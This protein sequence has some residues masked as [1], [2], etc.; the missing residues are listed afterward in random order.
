MTDAPR[1]EGVQ[2]TR[3]DAQ[4]VAEQEEHALAHGLRFRT[5][6]ARHDATGELAALTQLCTEDG[7]PG[8]AFQQITAVAKEHRGHRLGLLVKAANLQQLTGD[9]PGA[10]RILTGNAGANKYMIAINE[11]LGF[12]VSDQYREWSL[13]ITPDI[14]TAGERS[15]D[16]RLARHR[17]WT[18]TACGGGPELRRRGASDRDAQR[19]RWQPVIIRGPAADSPAT[20]WPRQPGP[21]LSSAAE[22][23]LVSPFAGR[24]G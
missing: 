24:T 13:D 9:D 11:M 17:G 7:T 22:I 8:W 20:G 2:A 1:D 6:A 4:R 14:G 3:W 5:V 19:P 23:C 21:L 15:R 12:R 18:F 16:V 10:R